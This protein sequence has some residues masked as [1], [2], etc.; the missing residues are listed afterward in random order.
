RA[1]NRLAKTVHAALRS[2]RGGMSATPQPA[3]SNKWLGALRWVRPVSATA[4]IK[5]TPATSLK[6]AYSRQVKGADL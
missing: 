5:E 1:E 4:G 6:A 2:G 3:E